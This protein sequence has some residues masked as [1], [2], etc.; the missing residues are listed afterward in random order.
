MLA[1]PNLYWTVQGECPVFLDFEKGTDSGTI[2]RAPKGHTGNSS[3]D[4][5]FTKQLQSPL[6]KCSDSVL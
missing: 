5:A 6:V 1:S 3:T 4:R 2:H